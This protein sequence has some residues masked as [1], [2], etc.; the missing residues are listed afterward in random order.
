MSQ[1]KPSQQTQSV[2]FQ[3]S[4]DITNGAV[5]NVWHTIVIL[6]Y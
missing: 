4:D 2:N 6:H 3:G 1:F 5:L